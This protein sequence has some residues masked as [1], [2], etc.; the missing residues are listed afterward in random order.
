MEALVLAKAVERAGG[1]DE[2]VAKPKAPQRSRGVKRVEALL[3]AAEQVFAEVG[4]GAASMNAIAQRAGAPIGSLYQFFPNKAV[5]GGALVERYETDLIETWR[6]A[7][8]P[9][10]PGDW[11]GF[12]DMLLDATLDCII[13]HA[14]FGALDEAQV[15]FQLR[16]NSQRE[17]ELALAALLAA[18][19][20]DA[21]EAD[22]K[23]VAIVALQIL[24]AAYALER[25]G[26]GG[27]IKKEMA[28]IM[29]SYFEAKLGGGRDASS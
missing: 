5:L 19:A 13:R 7:C 23:V 18:K 11:A 24:K 1:R 22:M 9:I 28:L 25:G 26:A 2:E 20:G 21:P 14:A 10:R 6:A 12:A 4:Y 29:R 8:A 3:A 15:Q 17:F 27:E 16:P